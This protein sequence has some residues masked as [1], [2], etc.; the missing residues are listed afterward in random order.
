MSTRGAALAATLVLLSAA[1]FAVRPRLDEVVVAEVPAPAP[2]ADVVFTS[3]TTEARMVR[4]PTPAIASSS[5]WTLLPQPA[6]ATP[7]LGVSAVLR[8][9]RFAPRIDIE[10]EVWAAFVD[11]AGDHRERWSAVADRLAR[12]GLECRREEAWVGGS[13]SVE[14][15]RDPGDVLLAVVV[16]ASSVGLARLTVDAST[17][18]IPVVGV[19]DVDIG[20]TV[21]DEGTFGR[22]ATIEAWAWSASAFP[23]PHRL[24]GAGVPAGALRVVSITAREPLTVSFADPM[25]LPA[26]TRGAPCLPRKRRV[27]ELAPGGS[28]PLVLRCRAEGWPP[29]DVTLAT[30]AQRP[31]SLVELGDRY[32]DYRRPGDYGNSLASPP[33]APSPRPTRD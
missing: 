27:Q 1:V 5:S 12:V 18:A 19:A 31:A 23:G 32:G 7:T 3:P 26:G 28:G 24:P 14:L 30:A 25:F 10:A 21:G 2:G 8:Q 11:S 15:A 13:V 4:A 17:V 9:P 20:V 22:G 29:I 33:Q 6:S 16:T